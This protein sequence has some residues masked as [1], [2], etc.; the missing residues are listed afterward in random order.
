MATGRTSRF[1][2][3]GMTAQI[4]TRRAMSTPRSFEGRPHSRSVSNTMREVLFQNDERDDKSHDH[5]REQSQLEHRAPERPPV[6]FEE[7]RELGGEHQQA[8]DR[9][10]QPDDEE[11][12]RHERVLAE[13]DLN[14][15]EKFDD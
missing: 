10:D 1:R 2:T 3:P 4:P 7:W 8:T 9:G 13:G 12:L 5:H 15:V 11:R 14:G 6:L